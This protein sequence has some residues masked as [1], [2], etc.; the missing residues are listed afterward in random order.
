MT[1]LLVILGGA[2][3]AP[4]RYLISTVVSERV[5][6]VFP[7]GT[8]AVNAAGSFLL[9]L[10]SMVVV[11]HGQAPWLAPLLGT[12]FCGALTTFS[13]F[14][15]ETVRLAEDGAGLEALENILANVVVGFVAW[16]A[17]GALAA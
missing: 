1:L 7:W 14:S 5:D 13:T 10:V 8:L 6:G 16:T 12:G 2:V 11:T 15:Y 3:G 17:G 9:G 4:A